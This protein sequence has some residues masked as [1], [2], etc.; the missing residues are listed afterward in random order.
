MAQALLQMLPLQQVPE[1]VQLQRLP[2]LSLLQAL[3]RAGD[4][5]R[6]AP[7]LPGHDHHQGHVLQPGAARA[8]PAIWPRLPSLRRR[9]L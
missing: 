6:H 9:R 1:P 8:A 5:V 7:D 2:G 4:Q 3:P